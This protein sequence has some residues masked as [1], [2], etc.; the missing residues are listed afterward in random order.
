MTEVNA[1]DLLASAARQLGDGDPRRPVAEIATLDPETT[2]PF[3]P[4]AALAIAIAAHVITA[5]ELPTFQ[6][7]RGDHG[8]RIRYFTAVGDGG[9]RLRACTVFVPELGTQR[10]V[11]LC[12]HA[13][14][15]NTAPAG[16]GSRCWDH[17]GDPP[18]DGL[19]RASPR[20]GDRAPGEDDRAYW[21]RRAADAARAEDRVHGPRRAERLAVAAAGA[22]LPLEEIC[23][24]TGEA[25]WTV[26]ALTEEPPPRPDD[27]DD[28]DDPDLWPL[29]LVPVRDLTVSDVRH[30]YGVFNDV[31]TDLA[32]ETV[33]ARE[34]VPYTYFRPVAGGPL[35]VNAGEVRFTLEWW[36]AQDH[37][38]RHRLVAR[39]DGRRRELYRPADEW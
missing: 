8:D 36:Q 39:A 32:P 22:G 19:W 11:E 23:R 12:G 37:L 34:G 15:A 33:L 26:H 25:A 20:P 30:V 6:V 31:R 4:F 29:V 24:A 5:W 18:P 13:W 1:A 38:P 28:A 17:L 16:P 21:L 27:V 10:V 35:V 3:R 14:C 7:E 2:R 9:P